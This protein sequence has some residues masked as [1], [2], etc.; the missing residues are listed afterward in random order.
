MSPTLNFENEKDEED[1]KEE[2]EEIK[3]LEKKIELNKK[4]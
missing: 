4:K 3:I 1:E 2:S